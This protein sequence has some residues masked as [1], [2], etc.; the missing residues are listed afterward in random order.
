MKRTW[1]LLTSTAVW[2]DLQ[3]FPP[4]NPWNQDVSQWQEH[5]NCAEHHRLGRIAD[6]RSPPTIYAK[7]A[8]IHQ[9]HIQSPLDIACPP[10][11]A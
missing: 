4:D 1:G 3:V 6:R 7:V 2:A 9:Q 11:T 10:E 8:V 5:P